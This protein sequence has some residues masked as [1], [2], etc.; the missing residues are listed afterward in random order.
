MGTVTK[1]TKLALQPRAI[2]RYER[3]G[4]KAG[5][6]GDVFDGTRPRF[7]RP[8]LVELGFVTVPRPI[9]DHAGLRRD[10]CELCY[11]PPGGHA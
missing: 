3:D 10:T 8:R 11:R 7:G 9:R 1:F 2:A 5:H 6:L 4:N